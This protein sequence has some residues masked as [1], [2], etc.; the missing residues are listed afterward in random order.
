MDGDPVVEA[1]FD[2]FSL[3]LPLPYRV[4]I[5]F[6]C[7]VWAWGLNLQYLQQVKIDVPALLR[8]S[9][10]PSDPHFRSTYRLATVLT[11]P[12][13]LSLFSFWIVTRFQA[14]DVLRWQILPQSYLLYFLL[15]FVLP[16]RRLSHLGRSR[17]LNT[18]RRVSLGGLAEAQDGKFGDILLA[19]VLTSYA[20]VFGDCFV[21]T[22]WGGQH[23]ANALKYAS[24]FPVI[25]L[26]ALQRG[27]DP[28][29]FNMTEAG[30]FRLWL[31][32][33]F[34]NSFYSFYWDVTKD[35]DL[36]FLTSARKPHR[37]GEYPYGLRRYR[38]FQSPRLY[39]IGIG[40]D[41]MLRCTW[42]FK[43]SP[44]L[45]HFNDLEGGIFMMEI[46]EVARRWMWIFLRVETEYVRVQTGPVADDIFLGEFSKIDQR[47]NI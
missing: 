14:R 6:V 46:L 10:H 29:S 7:G 23:L 45:D 42:S 35:W 11:I 33:V 8:Y 1:E 20:K 39:Y 37:M 13:V 24:A 31:F 43:L 17:F 38:Y 5:I 3:V 32:F 25:I 40:L 41:L 16:L 19:D 36:T 4:A 12:L 47:L 18:L 22:C 28:K 30:L 26:S 15:V 21:S 27:Y 44:H 2:A 9:P 34:L